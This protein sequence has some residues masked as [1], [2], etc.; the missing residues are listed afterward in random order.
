MMNPLSLGINAEGEL[1]SV[2]IPRNTPIPTIKK[3]I[4]YT[5]SDNQTS[6][7]FKV[8]QGERTR[9]IEN[10]LLRQ[11]S[12]SN[13]PPAPKDDIPVTVIFQI[14]FNGILTVSAEEK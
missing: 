2:V 5:C 1:M 14:D 6:I 9:S 4:Y 13:I 8:Y 7:L 11:F 10:H 3:D 12:L